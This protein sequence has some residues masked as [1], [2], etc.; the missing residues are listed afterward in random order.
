MLRGIID[1]FDLNVWMIIGVWFCTH[2]WRKVRQ[3]MVSLI[4][5]IGYRLAHL[6]AFILPKESPQKPKPK[7]KPDKPR[8]KKTPPKP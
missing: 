6:R 7:G 1:H 2:Y 4:D 3:R 8:G 5:D